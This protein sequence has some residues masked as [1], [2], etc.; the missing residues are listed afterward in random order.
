MKIDVIYIPSKEVLSMDLIR[1]EPGDI[2]YR[3][4]IIND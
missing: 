2:H 1:S 3:C 4:V